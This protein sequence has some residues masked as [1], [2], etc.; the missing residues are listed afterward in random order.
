[1][2]EDAV[3][4]TP[5]LTIGDDP[6]DPEG[7]VL[8]TDR[9]EAYMDEGRP[10][11]NNYTRHAKIGGGQHGEVYLC[12]K[13]D[14]RFPPGHPD[15]RI[16]VAMKSVKRDNPRAEQ[17][18]KLRT[19]RLPT[20]AH[21]PLAD[22]LNT[23][24][25]K[26]RKEIA[27]MKKCR[28]PHVVRL[29]EVIDDRMKDKIYM[30]MEYL[31]GG[32]VKWRDDRNRPILSVEQTRRIIRD[33]VL[34]LEYLHHQGII[35]RDI[36]PANLLWTEDR[37]QVKIADFGVSHFS[38][39]QRLASAGKA[40]VAEDP[41]DPIL[42]DDSDL[43]RRAGTPSFLAPEIIYEHRNDFSTRSSSLA[44]VAN[45]GS[46]SSSHTTTSQSLSKASSKRPPITKAIDVWALGVTLY[47]LLFGKT[48]FSSDPGAPS[49]EWKLYNSICN[50]DWT[51]DETMG[52]DRIP[53]GGR[54]PFRGS[55]GAPVINLLDQ[56]L[57]KDPKL[58]ITLEEVKRNPWFL[59]DLPEPKK[60]LQVT[61]PKGKIDVSLDETSDAMSSVHFRWNWGVV[62]SRRISSLFRRSRDANR[63]DRDRG[64]VRSDPHVRVRRQ[65]S[66]LPNE[67]TQLASMPASSS[68][69]DKGKQRAE[70]RSL[71]SPKQS[72]SKSLRSKSIE[73][74]PAT[75]GDSAS[76]STSALQAPAHLAERRRGSVSI[77][78]DPNHASSQSSPTSD[79]RR[80]RFTLFLNSISHWRPNK[81][82][83][84]GPSPTDTSGPSSTDVSVRPRT[85]NYGTQQSS[86]VTRRSEEALRM[87]RTRISSS[88]TLTADRRASSWGQGDQPIEFAEVL[89]LNS[90]DLSDSEMNIGAGGVGAGYPERP[91]TPRTPSRL[92]NM[93]STPRVE[94]APDERFGPACFDEDSSTIASAF[95]EDEPWENG[96]NMS[97]GEGEGEGEGDEEDGD[98]LGD[99]DSDDQDDNA[100]T[101]SPRKRQPPTQD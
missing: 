92:S 95:G 60:W 46:P 58:R 47:C 49:S 8:T 62:L 28:H 21:T 99:D 56:L 37:R 14:P 98:E 44:N 72:S 97:D 53:T 68:K 83:P 23:T 67:A 101:F 1:M 59:R 11:L 13:V 24:E 15:R 86:R 71:R 79:K 64:V 45:S 88:G 4:S 27:I 100:V 30:V 85:V 61:S 34:G 19:Q 12:Y 80:A 18:K 7:D 36:K 31:A 17:F 6:F 51:A 70:S 10:M 93:A 26:I 87:H 29:Y 43:T 32:E 3:S 25:A 55:E 63:D 2:N 42:L 5:R 66:N 96:S 48:A 78:T 65:K 40:G 73:H 77:L 16:P 33:A 75:R 41:E 94:S 9:L 74:W 81:Y 20:S 39:A 90:M 50:Q 22:R 52:S 57:Q 35:H 54:H 84:H 82:S 38:Y 89:S 69:H 76:A 91:F